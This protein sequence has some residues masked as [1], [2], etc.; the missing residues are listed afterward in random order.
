MQF[1]KLLQ[2]FSAKSL[3]KFSNSE[4]EEQRKKF[5]KKIF[6]IKKS[7]WIRRMQLKQHCHSFLTKVPISFTGSAKLMEKKYYLQKLFLQYLPPDI[8]NV[9]LITLLNFFVKL[10]ILFI[11]S[12]KKVEKKT[13]QRTLKNY[14]WTCRMQN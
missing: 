9:V 6:F 7:L 13:I 11:Q 14:L 12:P 1:Q 3:E 2:A 4:D 8:Q 10:R 5:P